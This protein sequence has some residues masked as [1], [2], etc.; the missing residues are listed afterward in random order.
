MYRKGFVIMQLLPADQVNFADFVEAFNAA[1]E[2]YF[3]RVVMNQR[4]F[5]NLIQ[6]D[7]ILM[8]HSVV[9]VEDAKIVGM[10]LLAKREQKGWIGGVGVIP[11]YRR[12]GIARQ[13]ME[14]LIAQARTLNIET[15]T[16]E[17]IEQ[18]HYALHLYK[19]LGF[20]PQRRLVVLENRTLSPLKNLTHEHY[21]VESV[22]PHQALI[23]F[24]AFHDEPNAW[25]R[26]LEAIKQ[27]A[28][29]CWIIKER[30]NA[31]VLGYCVFQV[32]F[33]DLLIIDI[34]FSPTYPNIAD[35]IK[36]LMNTIHQAYE[37]YSGHLINHPMAHRATQSL[38]EMGYQETLA[39]LEMS[40]FLSDQL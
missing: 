24:N 26:S 21:V 32:G 16:L 1:Y 30:N 40:L 12:R 28:Q 39:Q 38:I 36:V 4:S 27:L 29:E 9:C 31:Q 35:L 23:Y 13:M 33:G 18:N 17:V 14:Y 34:A 25:Q 11:H 22:M 2:D 19:T 20:Q 8:T 6:R 3:V 10:A 5:K 15:L 37:G 7:A